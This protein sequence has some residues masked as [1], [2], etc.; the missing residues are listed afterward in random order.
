[1]LRAARASFRDYRP[2]ISGP[3]TSGRLLPVRVHAMATSRAAP[4]NGLG[5]AT[6]SMAKCS[7]TLPPHHFALDSGVFH[8]APAPGDR[9]ANRSIDGLRQLQQVF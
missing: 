3:E 1:M 5:T 7:Q 2:A 6:P 4:L 8:L 9:I